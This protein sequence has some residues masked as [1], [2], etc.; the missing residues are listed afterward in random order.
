MLDTLNHTT[1]ALIPK[2][3]SPQEMKEYKPISLCNVLY[4]L[5]SKVLALR[6][7]EFLDEIIAE[8]QSAFIPGH[9]ITDNVL[10]AYE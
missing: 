4:K 3:R 8:E 5:C 10:I 9:L 2:T 6:L 1:I 7:R